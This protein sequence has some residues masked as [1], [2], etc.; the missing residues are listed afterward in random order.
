M[1]IASALSVLKSL[2]FGFSSMWEL[3]ESNFTC[4]YIYR[5]YMEVI[6]SYIWSILSTC[7]SYF[8]LIIQN[9]ELYVM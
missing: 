9:W 5:S 3:Y 8:K 7:R 2:S 1:S 4:M 6:W